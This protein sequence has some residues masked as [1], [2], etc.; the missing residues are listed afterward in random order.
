MS[1]TTIILKSSIIRRGG[2]FKLGLRVPKSKSLQ[3]NSVRIFGWSVLRS[4]EEICWLH[5][6]ASLRRTFRRLKKKVFLRKVALRWLNSAAI[7]DHLEL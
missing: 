1:P 4:A 5:S 7:R 2:T 6:L 3:R